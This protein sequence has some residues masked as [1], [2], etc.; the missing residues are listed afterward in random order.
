[1]WG[2]YGAGVEY[3][4]QLASTT[5]RTPDMHTLDISELYVQLVEN[6]SRQ[7]SNMVFYPE[8]WSH[9]KVGHVQLKP[10]AYIEVGG[11]AYY[12]EIDRNSEWESQLTAK[13]RRYIQAIDS[14]HWPEDR[15]FPLVIW[16]VPNE[17][18]KKYL[19]NIIHRLGETELFQVTLFDEA[20]RLL[21][22]RKTDAHV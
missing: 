19:E 20:A 21:T 10:D 12:A 14:G 3:V 16:T 11:V 8:P 4:Y 2:A 15:A 17:A 9:T 22:E 13:C 6:Q 18:R 5:A 1:M 7:V